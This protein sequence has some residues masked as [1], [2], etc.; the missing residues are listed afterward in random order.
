MGG[1]G[2]GG[3]LEDV[4]VVLVDEVGGVAAADA[5]VVELG[6]RAAGAGVAHLPEVVLHAALE[7]VVRGQVAQPQLARLLVGGGAAAAVGVALAVG[8]VEAVRGDLPHFGDEFPGPVDGFLLEI[9]AEGPVAEHLEER[10][11]I[12]VQTHVFEVI[13]LAAR[14][15]A[16][17]GVDGSLE[18]GHRGGWVGLRGAR[19]WVRRPV[20]TASQL[21]EP[22]PGRLA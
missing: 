10:V 8:G 11:V 15:D 12:G 7:D 20:N 16:L 6:A 14:A 19:G 4:G 17:L 5:V 2:W 13:V 21:I 22:A 3:G 18:R 9:I 1:G